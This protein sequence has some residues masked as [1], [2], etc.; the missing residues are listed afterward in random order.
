MRTLVLTLA[1]FT[2]GSAFA[3]AE[4]PAKAKLTG[5]V[6][7]PKDVEGFDGQ[8]LDVRLYKY[9]PR[10]ADKAADLVDQLLVKDFSH[11]TGKETKKEFV[12]GA[13]ADLDPG[14]N[15]Y[16]TCFVIDG[17]GNRTHMGK[18][19]HDKNGIGNVLTGG[20]PKAIAISVLPIK[21]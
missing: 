5:A 10:I 17:K 15:Y 1:V 7:I 12:L 13:E 14:K 2:C 6:V 16:V 20:N 18:C 19:D 4:E 21:R 9:D 8:V 3:S 11:A